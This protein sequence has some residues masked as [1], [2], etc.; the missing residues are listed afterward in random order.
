MTAVS[1]PSYGR[2]V[3]PARV[4]RIQAI[5]GEVAARYAVARCGHWPDQSGDDLPLVRQRRYGMRCQPRQW[6]PTRLRRRPLRPGVQNPH[7]LP[8][9]ML[10]DT[11]FNETT[12]LLLF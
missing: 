4:T 11:V 9:R 5:S 12:P 8:H 3:D 6:P 7:D 10:V 1:S 2:C